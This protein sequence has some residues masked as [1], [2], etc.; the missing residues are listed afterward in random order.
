MVIILLPGLFRS[1]SWSFDVRI[2]LTDD[3][4]LDLPPGQSHA[5]VFSQL[6]KQSLQILA[7]GSSYDSISPS[8]LFGRSNNI[9]KKQ[10]LSLVD[11][12]IS[13]S[14][15]RSN[16]LSGGSSVQHR[17]SG[18]QWSIVHWYS[19]DVDSRS[20]SKESLFLLLFS[21]GCLVVKPVVAAS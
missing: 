21:G 17:R 16:R 15:F 8:G 13:T 4:Q 10:F 5:F 1:I 3:Y 7:A 9:E 18:H 12:S 2:S 14:M 6:D 11:R 19:Y 20:V